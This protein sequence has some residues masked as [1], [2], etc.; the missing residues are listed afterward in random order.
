MAKRTGIG[1]NLYAGAFNL[2]GDVGAINTI[3]SS[4]AL[5]DTTAIDKDAF[6]RLPGIGDG[7]IDFTGFFDRAT[8]TVHT[9]LGS[10]FGTANVHLTAA[11]GTAIGDPA[12]SLIAQKANYNTTR[13]QDGSLAVAMT[14]QSAGG[15]GTEWGQLLTPGRAVTTAPGTASTSADGGAATSAGA[16]AYLHVFAVAAG[17]VTISVVDSADDATFAAVT[18]LSFTATSAGMAQRVETAAGATIRRYLRYVVSGGT[19]TFA[20]NVSRNP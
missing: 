11:V 19:A 3:G 5:L 4:R 16:S 2:S 7:T 9:A 8:D 6:E 1:A 15:Y 17:T 12:A 14:G 20:L 10:A 13:G 18:G